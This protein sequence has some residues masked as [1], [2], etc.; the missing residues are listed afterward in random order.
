MFPTQKHL[1]MQRLNQAWNG[2]DHL[3]WDYM[4]QF[5][6]NPPLKEEYMCRS[7]EVQASYEYHKQSLKS[8]NISI[9]EY[10]L[11]T[12]FDDPLLVAR[13]WN[14]VPNKF[15]ILLCP[16]IQHLLIW[17]HPDAIMSDD[18]IISA[19]DG[20]MREHNYIKYIYYRNMPAMRSV[21]VLDHFQIYVQ[22]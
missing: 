12:H 22:T 18:D 6:M 3:T 11:S 16:D 2:I 19:I 10:L 7:P 1:L 13:G 21:P 20:W 8:Q 4:S 14:I 17:I 5:H 9:K 15:P